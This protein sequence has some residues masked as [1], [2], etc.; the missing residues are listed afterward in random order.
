SGPDAALRDVPE[1]DG[2]RRVRAVQAHAA[3]VPAPRLRLRPA[4]PGLPRAAVQS[5]FK[6]K[7]QT[8]K[9]DKTWRLLVKKVT[10][11]KVMSSL[12]ERKVVPEVV[13]ESWARYNRRGAK[14]R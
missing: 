12:A 8:G 9:A 2:A 5:H 4:G 11:A 7:A 13:A 3:A 10:R 6:A 14:L 1:K